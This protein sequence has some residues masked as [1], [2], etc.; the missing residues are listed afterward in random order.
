MERQLDR[1][2]AYQEIQS[3]MARYEV[4]H[5]PAQINRSSEVF[6]MTR[7]DVSVEISD[8]GVW[9]GPEALRHLFEEV[10]NVP[11]KGTV[12]EHH[13]TT[14]MIEVA[15]DG[16]TAK[17]VFWS[18]GFE[19]L[20]TIGDQAAGDPRDNE[21]RTYW[22]WGKYAADFIRESGKWKI[23]HL[24][25]FRLLRTDYYKSPVDAYREV[26]TGAPNRSDFPGVEP[27]TF[28]HPYSADDERTPVPVNPEPYESYQG[29][30]DWWFGEWKDRLGYVPPQY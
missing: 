17:A 5:T 11:R 30:F 28:H 29:E 25:W 12:T 2:R 7:D 27:P 8:W 20:P 10:M 18:P 9:R 13:L 14:P 4:I 15:G 22:A 24:K 21:I 6:A 1:L 3:V 23:W 16:Q 26:M 19:I